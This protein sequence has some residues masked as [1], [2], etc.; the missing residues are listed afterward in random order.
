MAGYRP[1][2]LYAGG[3]LTD[4]LGRRNARCRPRRLYAGGALTDQLRRRNAHAVAPVG[5]TPNGTRLGVSRW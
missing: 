1:R 4:Q 3:A 2:R 5:F